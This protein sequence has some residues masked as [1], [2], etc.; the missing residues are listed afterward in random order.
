MAELN[1]LLASP[2]SNIEFF[3]DIGM[4]LNEIMMALEEYAAATGME[5]DFLE[6]IANALM[7][8][9]QLK[10]DM[11]AAAGIET[12]PATP[13]PGEAAAI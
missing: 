12:A 7:K 1:E 3:A 4:T 5:L 11:K 10:E 2:E 13:A 6:D 8:I 9:K